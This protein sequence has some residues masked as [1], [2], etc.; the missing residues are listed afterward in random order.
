M[1]IIFNAAFHDSDSNSVVS[2]QVL[3]Q[4]NVQCN[5]QTQPP[6]TICVSSLRNA[7]PVDVN[8]IKAEP[9]VRLYM[10]INFYDYPK[11]VAFE[12]GH[13]RRFLGTIFFF[14]LNHNNEFTLR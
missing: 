12:P 13:F 5:G 1:R 10:P 2:F 3:N 14:H 7:E 4:L 11:K 6:D 8:V 9:D